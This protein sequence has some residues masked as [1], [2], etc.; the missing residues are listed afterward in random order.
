MDTKLGWRGL[1][2]GVALGICL[3]LAPQARAETDEAAEPMAAS[4]SS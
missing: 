2:G 3:L 1:G 4:R